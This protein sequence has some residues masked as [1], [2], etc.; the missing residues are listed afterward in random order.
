MV[1]P[2]KN[3][4]RG[5]LE[6]AIRSEAEKNPEFLEAL[7]KNPH[8][9]LREKFKLEIPQHIKIHCHVEEPNTWHIVISGT[10]TPS[11][12]SGE[13]LKDVAGGDCWV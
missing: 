10:S 5:E 12:M 3:P 1:N 6:N 4:K 2:G 9:A 11:Q 8:E 7:K 13:D